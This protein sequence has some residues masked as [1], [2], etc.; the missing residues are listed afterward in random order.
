MNVKRKERIISPEVKVHISGLYIEDC[1]CERILFIACLFT[2]MLLWLL[3]PDT[4]YFAYDNVANKVGK[5]T[6]QNLQDVP[7]NPSEQHMLKKRHEF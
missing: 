2:H 6:M 7:L 5:M 4:E 3:Q 1:I